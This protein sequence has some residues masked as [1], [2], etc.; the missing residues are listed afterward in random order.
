MAVTLR[1]RK[2]LLK[3]NC[4]PDCNSEDRSKPAGYILNRTRESKIEIP[5]NN[6]YSLIRA[7]HSPSLDQSRNSTLTQGRLMP[8]K[9]ARTEVDEA[10]ADTLKGVTYVTSDVEVTPATFVTGAAK[11]SGKSM[12]G[13][14]RVGAPSRELARRQGGSAMM[15]GLVFF[16][17]ACLALA[18]PFGPKALQALLAN[19]RAKP[20]F[21]NPVQRWSEPCRAERN[22]PMRFALKPASSFT[23]SSTSL[24]LMWP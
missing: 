1:G 12:E 21:W 10:A 19:H 16:A 22:T 2:Q 11:E 9:T 8:A 3:R 18:G 7:K 5:V 4:N 15:R 6:T 24:A 23:P 20:H 17:V 14:L 13:P